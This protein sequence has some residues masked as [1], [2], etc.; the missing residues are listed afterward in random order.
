MTAQD[1]LISLIRGVLNE[2]YKIEYD[3]CDWQK[4]YSLAC[5]HSVVNLLYYA[6]EKGDTNIP[7]S[8]KSRLQG[9]FMS[10]VMQ[11]HKQKQCFAVLSREFAEN[12]IRF[13]S[14]KG[15]SVRDAYPEEEMRSS[16]DVDLFYD[17]AYTDRMHEIAQR[18]GFVLRETGENHYEYEKGNITV[19]F[20][21]ALTP[22]NSFLNEYYKDVWEKLKTDDGLKHSFT[23]EDN[24]IYIILHFVKHFFSGGGGIRQMADIYMYNKKYLQMDREYLN[25]EFEKLGISVFV[26]TIESI[27]FKMFNDQSYTEEEKE[28]LDFIISGDTYG[29]ASSAL[30]SKFKGKTET[31]TRINYI[32]YRIFPPFE[33]MKNLYGFL[34]KA[35]LLLPVC[36]VV[37]WFD[38]IFKRKERI[39]RVI[40]T[41]KDTEFNSQADTVMKIVDLKGKTSRFF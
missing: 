11:L 8:I 24:Y 21:Y 12:K 39:S 31:H 4:I 13:L 37:R 18:L 30:E 16:C 38:V 33:K 25:A 28:V 1:N 36:W 14:L 9:H 32:I 3:D 7:D 41:A 23:T 27:A 35:P 29:S 19:E 5:E 22:P 2:D 17:S 40:K 34:E 6:V 26:K 10:L 15:Q 20:H